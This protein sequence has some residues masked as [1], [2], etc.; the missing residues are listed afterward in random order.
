MPRKAEYIRLQARS[1]FN[2]YKCR[3]SKCEYRKTFTKLP[4]LMRVT[5]RCPCGSR[6]W[7]VDW[8]RTTRKEHRRVLCHCP[9][10]HFPHRGGDSSCN[11]KI[12]EES[13]V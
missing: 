6:N 4:D 10:R 11:P 3:C 9:A 8:Y 7:R 2:R 1:K 12:V 5:P 13:Q